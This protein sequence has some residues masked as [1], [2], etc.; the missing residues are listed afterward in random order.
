MFLNLYYPGYPCLDDG[1]RR[2]TSYDISVLHGDVPRVTSHGTSVL[3]GGVFRVT[4]Y[5][6]I[7]F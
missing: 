3:V 2:V 7:R 1:V 6:I 5:G 4:S